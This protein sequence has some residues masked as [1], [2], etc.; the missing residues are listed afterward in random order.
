M[1]GREHRARL[2][3]VKQALLSAA[4]VLSQPARHSVLDLARLAVKDGRCL[5]VACQAEARRSKDL[6]NMV[7]NSIQNKIKRMK[8]NPPIRK[9]KP[10]KH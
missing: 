6:K 1:G 10:L 8:A 4:P 7:E 2:L 5:T 9:E 3:V